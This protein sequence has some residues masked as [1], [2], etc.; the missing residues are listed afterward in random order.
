MQRGKAWLTCVPDLS[1]DA[2]ALNGHG[3]GGELDADGGLGV[4]VDF[5]LGESHEEVALSDAA[6]ADEND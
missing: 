6:V 2:L 1:L 3:T 4:E 5:V